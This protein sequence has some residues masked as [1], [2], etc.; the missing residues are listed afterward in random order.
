MGRVGGSSGVLSLVFGGGIIDRLP[1]QWPGISSGLLVIL[2]FFLALPFFNAGMAR[3]QNWDSQAFLFEYEHPLPLLS[4]G[5]AA[6]VTA[7]AEIVLPILLVLGLLG[8]FAALGLAV[9]AATI[10][11]LIG[12]AYAIEAEQFPWM[13]AGLLLFV[14]GPGRL[15]L[16]HGIHGLLSGHRGEGSLSLPVCVVFSLVFLLALLEKGGVWETWL[17]WF[18]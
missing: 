16:D 4:P 15:S 9:M 12:G 13:L 8:R 10:Y 3:F 1:G 18:F 6:S 2:R 5:M 11:F 7:A 17:G 14:T